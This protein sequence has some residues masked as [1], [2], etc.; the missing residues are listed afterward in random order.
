MNIH[1]IEKFRI[2]KKK[3]MIDSTTLYS[4]AAVSGCLVARV[5]ADMQRLGSAASA[6]RKSFSKHAVTC[7]SRSDRIAKELTDGSRL[8]PPPVGVF[9]L[10][11]ALVVVTRGRARWELVFGSV[12]VVV[13]VEVVVPKYSFSFPEPAPI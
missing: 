11:G 10:G 13:V 9:G 7:H 3:K 4:S 12:E 8:D 1:F 2:F 5:A 6:A